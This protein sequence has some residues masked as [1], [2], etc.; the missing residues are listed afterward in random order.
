MGKQR[1]LAAVPV[2][3]L[4]L[5]AGCGGNDSG[6]E[7]PS[8]GGASSQAAD[9]EQQQAEYDACLREHGLELPEEGEDPGGVDI[10][11]ETLAS[12]MQAC[13]DLAPASGESLEFSPEDIEELRAWT[14][15]M[16]EE[17]IDIPD[18]DSDGVIDLEGVDPQS[19]EYT[20]ADQECA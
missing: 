9:P 4:L 17:G 7:V 20:A 3:A 12:A 10:D 8:A 13:E 1:V 6:E 15:C 5:A 19:D 18:P 11:D 14:E 16:R 2:L